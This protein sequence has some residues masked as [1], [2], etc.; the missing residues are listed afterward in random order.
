MVDPVFLNVNLG[1]ISLKSNPNISA[2]VLPKG[3]FLKSVGV[4][5]KLIVLFSSY[6]A[7][8]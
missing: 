8:S 3:F 1:F 7:L 5:L 6:S 2:Q 4:L